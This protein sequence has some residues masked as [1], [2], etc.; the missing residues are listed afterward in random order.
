MDMPARTL[1]FLC[2]QRDIEN[3]CECLDDLFKEF[4]H[5]H[6]LH[7]DQALDL[8]QGYFNKAIGSLERYSTASPPPTDRGFA[9]K[10][11][12][13]RDAEMAAQGLLRLIG[14]LQ[15]AETPPLNLT[16]HVIQVIRTFL[17]CS[18]PDVIRSERLVE[19]LLLESSPS[20]LSKA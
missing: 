19:E 2:A 9:I 11:T 15:T 12:C 1:P 14:G 13:V 17:L 20:L 10:P 4:G 5:K 18:F 16:S 6:S 8:A 7:P 3:A